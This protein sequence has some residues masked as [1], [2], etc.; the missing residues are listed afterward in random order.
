MTPVDELR[1]LLEAVEEEPNFSAKQKI[2]TM[3]RQKVDEI[4]S[5]LKPAETSTHEFLE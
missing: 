3:I 5:L 4:E 1:V 2:M